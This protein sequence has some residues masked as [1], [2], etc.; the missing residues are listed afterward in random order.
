METAVLELEEFQ[1]EDI[2]SLNHSR[3]INR[4][5]VALDKYDAKFDTF[6]ELELELITGKCKPDIC[7]YPNLQYD[8]WSEEHK[9]KIAPITTI[10]ILSYQ[11]G[12][13]DLLIKA[14][15]IYFPSGVKSSWFVEP[16]FGIVHIALPGRE[17]LTF[18][19]KDQLEDPVN[20]IVLDLKKVFS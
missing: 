4:L 13:E 3:I 14:K 18:T 16:A 12:V 10:E 19:K 17:T 2:M 6:P 15:D 5:C 11:Q 1:T 7:I 20:G 9:V 8:W